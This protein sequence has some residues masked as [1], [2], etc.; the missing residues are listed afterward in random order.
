MTKAG[1][2]F[3]V[4]G[5]VVYFLAGQ[6]QIGW[7]YLF[8]AIIWSLLVLSAILPWFSLKSLQVERRVL[9]PT[10]AHSQ[11][12][13]PLEDETVEVELKV[14]NSGRLARHFIKVLEDCPFEQPKKR[15]RTFLVTSLKPRSTTVFSYTATGYR[16]GYYASSNT[17][18]Q[19]SGPLEL[20]VRRRTFQLP[21]NLTVYPAYYQMEG[22][23]VADAAWTD[24]GNAVKSR[25]AA[26]FYSSR[27]YQPG[28]PLRHIHW[29]NTAR[30]GRFM[31]K[32]FEQASQDSVTVAFETGRDFGRGRQTTLEYS[33]K[34]TASLAKLCANSGRSIDIV[35]GEALLYNAAWREAMDY[36]A[37]LEVGGKAVLAELVTA[38]K[39]GRVIVAIVPAIEAE[40]AL[41]LS[42]LAEQ[43]NWLVVVL[44][45]GFTPNE[46]PAE[47][48]SRLK[49]GNS[50]IISCSRG[51][52][53][54]AIKELSNSLSFASKLP[55]AVG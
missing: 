54:M 39:L 26:E 17:T 10:S 2:G 18:L 34:I 47:F 28:E 19:A 1:F 24:W 8:D 27:E 22:L 53:E 43:V 40:L 37:H 44:L 20:M 36:L 31:L 32:E 29:R 30:L 48:A 42:R 11:L 9:L 13:G 33:I 49:K 3:I 35:A 45:E 51:N 21:L 25:A 5:G 4:A 6:T 38:P 46:I 41:T 55:A 23:S 50:P 12:G 14:T 16:R 15:R 7:L 52:L